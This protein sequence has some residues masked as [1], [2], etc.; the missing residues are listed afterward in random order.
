MTRLAVEPQWLLQGPLIGARCV[1]KAI[2]IASSAGADAIRAEANP[3]LG[4]V[5]TLLDL[6][7]F[8]QYGAANSAGGFRRVYLQKSLDCETGVSF[9]G[10]QAE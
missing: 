3:D 9:F 1:R 8:E 7:G 5:R 4:D 6:F 2:E 10:T